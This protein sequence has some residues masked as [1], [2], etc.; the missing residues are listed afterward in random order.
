MCVS[1]LIYR[2]HEPEEKE[3]AGRAGKR[4]E[5]SDKSSVALIRRQFH[6]SATAILFYCSLFAVVT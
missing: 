2:E 4:E 1:V 3:R 5:E 6:P